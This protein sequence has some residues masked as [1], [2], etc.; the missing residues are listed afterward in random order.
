MSLPLD[1]SLNQPQQ[2]P[3]PSGGHSLPIK[4]IS[5]VQRPPQVPEES[6]QP[7]AQSDATSEAA[8]TFADDDETIWRA[9]AMALGRASYFTY[10]SKSMQFEQA[11]DELASGW[12]AS[13]Q[14]REQRISWQRARDFARDAWDQARAALEY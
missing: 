13:Q 4:P 14:S 12:D 10:G 6:T 11:E 8:S 3:S 9:A 1:S 7:P 5:A 2:P